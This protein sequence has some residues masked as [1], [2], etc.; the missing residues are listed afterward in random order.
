M[1]EMWKYKVWIKVNMYY[2][3]SNLQDKKQIQSYHCPPNRYVSPFGS[4]LSPSSAIGS[5]WLVKSSQLSWVIIQ[6]QFSPRPVGWPWHGGLG[7]S[8]A[9]AIDGGPL[10]CSSQEAVM[11]I[12]KASG[13]FPRIWQHKPSEICLDKTYAVLYNTR[14]RAT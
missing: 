7:I 9:T 14:R 4:S 8:L 5:L 6:S 12:L 3:N 10:N 13:R 11:L 2:Y 1:N